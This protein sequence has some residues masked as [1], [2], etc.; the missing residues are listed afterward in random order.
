MHSLKW[1]I[2]MAL[3]ADDATGVSVQAIRDAFIA[4]IPDRDALAAR[5]GWPRGEIDT[6]DAYAGAD[7]VYTFP[8][9]RTV[10]RTCSGYFAVDEVAWPHYELADRCPTVVFRRLG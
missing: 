1:R 3:Q 4:A 8:W 7:A 6:I 10:E 2:A 5:T 9:L